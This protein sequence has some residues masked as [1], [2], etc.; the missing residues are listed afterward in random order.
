MLKNDTLINGVV[1]G[2]LFLS[3]SYGII[4]GLNY[5]WTEL[6]QKYN[7][8]TAP[9]LQLVVLF[10]NLIFFRYMLV[11]KKCFEKA[12]GVF[13]VIAISAAVYVLINKAHL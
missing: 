5:C 4:Y 10:F 13:L 11:N 2:F 3:A 8:F 6:L 9:K 1:V 12:R 7:Y